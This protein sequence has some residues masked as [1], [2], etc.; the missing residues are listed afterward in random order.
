MKPRFGCRQER[1]LLHAYLDDRVEADRRLAFE[2]HLDDCADCRRA[3]AFESAVE[4]AI[5]RATGPEFDADF[6]TRIVSAVSARLDAAAARPHAAPGGAAR[7]RIAVLAAIAAALLIAAGLVAVRFFAARD[8][9]HP[10]AEREVA[11]PRGASEDG[12]AETGGAAPVAASTTVAGSESTLDRAALDAARRQVRESLI[13]VAAAP[14]APAAMPARLAALAADDWPIPA[15]LR[16]AIDDP[17]PAVA[18]GAMRV[19]VAAELP[20]CAP[21]IRRAARRPATAAVAIESLGR[22]GD[23]ESIALIDRA[24]RSPDLAPAAIDA[25]RALGGEEA[26]ARL[27]TA[28]ADPALGER[29]VD[30]LAA[31][32]ADGIGALLAHA[33]RGD[34]FVAAELER[35]AIP[36][37]DQLSVILRTVVDPDRV[38]AAIARAARFGDRA[39]SDLLALLATNS[40]RDAALDGLVAIGSRAALESLLAAAAR[41]NLPQPRGGEAIRA[42][43]SGFLDPDAVAAREAASAHGAA[44]LEILLAADAID[45]SAR[46]LHAIAAEPRVPLA[47]RVAVA[48]ALADR[49]LLA[50]DLATRLAGEAFASGRGD[51]AARSL[52]A[53]AAAGADLEPL[54]LS[55]SFPAIGEARSKALQIA[56][57]WRRD[58]DPPTASE[59][60][61]LTRRVERAMP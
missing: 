36:T 58:G 19:A 8:R 56:L 7:R 11:E 26:I 43:V 46:L 38:T 13:E 52:L 28:L 40:V 51:L 47:S 20:S 15:L 3:V 14:R 45:E 55:R 6:E 30:A 12:G 61:N 41:G 33:G 37:Y 53:A 31:L 5:H 42:I 4:E 59:C 57:R 9:A 25:L 21:A 18:I 17:E 27:E 32:G 49:G 34:R 10:S 22:I 44:L 1:S 60:E 35:R 50:A 24:L 2:R 48:F 29:A 39:V 16:S 54:A 23:L